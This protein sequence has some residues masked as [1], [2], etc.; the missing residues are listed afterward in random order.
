MVR[1]KR[2]MGILPVAVTL[3]GWVVTAVLQPTV[4]AIVNRALDREKTKQRVEIAHVTVSSSVIDAI[5]DKVRKV[6][7]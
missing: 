7:P 1:R 3:T 2:S 6:M 4:T 5:R